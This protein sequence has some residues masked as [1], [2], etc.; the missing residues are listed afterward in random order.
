[1]WQNSFKLATALRLAYPSARIVLTL[2]DPETL[3]FRWFQHYVTRRMVYKGGQK[4][5]QKASP[6]DLLREAKT[7]F[8]LRS[9][10]EVYSAA[11][12][13]GCVYTERA[14]RVANS[15]ASTFFANSLFGSLEPHLCA[16]RLKQAIAF[17]SDLRG[18]L[19]AGF[20]LGSTLEVVFMENWAAEGDRYL[21]KI[22][23]ML[24]LPPNEAHG[25]SF[26]KHVYSVRPLLQPNNALSDVDAAPKS[27][28]VARVAAQTCCALL[29][30]L[31]TKPKWP[32]CQNVTERLSQP[33]ACFVG[34]SPNALA[35]RQYS[36]RWHLL[37]RLWNGPVART[38]RDH[39]R[40]QDRDHARG[41]EARDGTGGGG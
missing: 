41:A 1:M 9:L 15:L 33:A 30:R 10:I 6:D 22:F 27:P 13:E 32:S 19:R 12:P 17:E 26:T 14:R 31:N 39:A 23:H 34:A 29:S 35:K 40:D 37:D 5:R 28:M 24:G 7:R 4:A 2:C 20:E 18:F 8:G 36:K 25:A 11:N 3:R 21:D 16:T 38:T